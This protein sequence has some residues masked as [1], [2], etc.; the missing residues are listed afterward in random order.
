MGLFRRKRRPEPLQPAPKGEA[1]AIPATREELSV[2]R[3]PHGQIAEQYRRLRN[4][5][6]ALNPDGAPR[7]VVMTSSIRGEGKSVATLNLALAF[8][9][10]P[11][12]RIA[13]LDGDLR[14]PSLEKYLGLPR[15]QGITEVLRGQL[16]LAAAV[17]PTSIERLDLIGAGARPENP[18]EIMNL[19]RIKTVLHSLKRDYD[20]ILIDTPPALTIND[21]S[22]LG[23]IA[24]GIVFVVRL[25][26]TPKHLVEETQQVL[27]TLGGNILGTCLTGAFL[28]D[29]TYQPY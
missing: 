18:S 29:K 23:A 3:D 1:R 14:D 21:P 13:L 10:M 9:E 22:M 16:P 12:M 15:R 7:T 19:D 5:L 26:Y 11:R 25:G 17:R 20:Y 4:S 24:D 28:S 8:V 6:Q 2:L 27:E